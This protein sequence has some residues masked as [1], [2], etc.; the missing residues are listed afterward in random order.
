ML[1]LRELVVVD[2]GEVERHRAGVLR[3]PREQVGFGTEPERERGDDLFADRVEGR[4]RHLRELLREVVEQQPGPF[5]QHGDGRVAAHRAEGLRT[6]LSH[7]GEEDAHLFL[8][9]PERALTTRD[10]GD[11]MHDVL[12]FGQ[13]LEPH[14]ARIEPL[15]PRV[16]GRQL[17]L[18]LLVLDD[19]TRGRV[20]HEHATGLQTSA[21]LDPLGGEVEHAGLAA[22]HD[23]SV[24]GLGP[25][26]GTQPVAVERRTD[27]R[28]IGEDERRRTVPGLHLDG[29]V[30]VERAQIRV[31]VGLLLVGL[32][33]HHHDGVGQ[34][35]AGESEQLEHLVERGRVAG[36]VG[37]DRQERLHV[38]EQLGL[39]LRLARPHPVA[40]ALDRVD[41]TVVREHAQGLGERPGGEGVGRV[42]RVHDCE[43]GRE[44]LVLQVGV[45]RLEL[46]GG[47]HPLVAERAARE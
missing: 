46:Q 32:G 10:R 35:A 45:E 38:A 33:H 15:L 6:H 25:A 20:D 23:E 30:V 9:V 4:V 47:D 19:A 7:R 24:G 36:T 11:R 22:D 18:D 26:P 40:V 43:F 12:A 16:Q 2:D 44:A 37:A 5:A 34:A 1:D 8:G 27:E 13:V 17:A 31:D 41:L 28:A 39:E 21:T 3:P 42:P 29:V 14:A